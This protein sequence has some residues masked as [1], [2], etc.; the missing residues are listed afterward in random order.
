MPFPFYVQTVST[1]PISSAFWLANVGLNISI[2]ACSW[3][4]GLILCVVF[5]PDLIFFCLW[6][7]RTRATHG[8]T[9]C[10]LNVLAILLV[11]SSYTPRC[12]ALTG[13]RICCSPV[14]SLLGSPVSHCSSCRPLCVGLRR[15]GPDFGLRRRRRLRC[16]CHLRCSHRRRRHCGRRACMRAWRHPPL[17]CGDAGASCAVLPKTQP[18]SCVFTANAYVPTSM[19]LVETQAPSENA[20]WSRRHSST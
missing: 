12:I 7:T 13:S 20:E 14:V 15:R 8:A 18:A 6:S 19:L 4:C 3:H 16:C 5:G 17:M 10:L 9:F 11:F 1:L 2:A